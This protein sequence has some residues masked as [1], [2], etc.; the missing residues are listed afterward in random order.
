MADPQGADVREDSPSVAQRDPRLAPS[1][2]GE[3]LGHADQR[4]V[5]GVFAGPQVGQAGQ[6]GLGGRG[7][8][9]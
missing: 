1:G 2:G 7:I 6:H 3:A 5:L 4:L 8:A 9:A